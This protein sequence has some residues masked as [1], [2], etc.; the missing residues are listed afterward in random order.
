M[1]FKDINTLYERGSIVE[2]KVI[3]KSTDKQ[4]VFFD[5]DDITAHLHITELS[6]SHVLAEKL[7]NIIRVGELITSVII[8]FDLEKKTRR[9]KP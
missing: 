3:K 2:L 7:F 6:N 1:E 9:V 4:I 5:L 8:D